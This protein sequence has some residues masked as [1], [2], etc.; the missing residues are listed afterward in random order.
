M[1]Y[2]VMHKDTPL[3][4]FNIAKSLTETIELLG[5]TPSKLI[6]YGARLNPIQSYEVTSESLSDWL[7][8]RRLP[9]NRKHIDKILKEGG[10]RSS[11]LEDIIK[12]TMMLSVND[13]YWIKEIDSK[14]SWAEVSLYDNPISKTIA[15]TAFSGDIQ[16]ANKIIRNSPEYT[17][18]GSLAKCWVRE[19]GELKLYKENGQSNE[20]YNEYYCSQILRQLGLNHIDYGIKLY[21]DRLINV[22]NCFTNKEYGMIPLSALWRYSLELEGLLAWIGKY[23]T[24]DILKAFTDMIFFDSIVLNID[25]HAGNIGFIIDNNTNDIISLAPI[26]DNGL[27]LEGEADYSISTFRI[28]QNDIF[29]Y[30]LT[31]ERRIKLK[32]LNIEQH[33]RYRLSKDEFE[34]KKNILKRVNKA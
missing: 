33:P 8:S 26:Y 3:I 34:N 25:R 21:R 2:I 1:E 13:V 32:C 19:R 12:I 29:N 22:C 7:Y 15:Y 5:Y 10:I 27:S 20:V 14:I 17:T 11:T 16:R 18:N 30:L 23:F 24:P 9:T 4:T 31:E 6:P 28:L